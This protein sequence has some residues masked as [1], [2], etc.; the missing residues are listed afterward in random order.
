MTGQIDGAINDLPVWS[1]AL[2]VNAGKAKI[3]TQF[4]TG[5]QYGLG[6]KLDNAAL[7]NVVD[8]VLA[9]AKTDGTY[10]EIYTKWIG[11]APQN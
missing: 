2:K 7:K 8:E 10:D 5:E 3:A 4:D 9:Q 1:E 11:D 6:M